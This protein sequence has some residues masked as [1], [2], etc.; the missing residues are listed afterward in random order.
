MKKIQLQILCSCLLLLSPICDASESHNNAMT[1]E[2]VNRTFILNYKDMV[3]AHCVAKAYHGDR[4]AA[5][6]AGSSVSALQDWLDYYMDKSIDEEVRLINSYLSRDYF[7]PLAE[8]EVN[9]LKFDFLK[10]LDLYH[11]KE[12]DKLARKVVPY[13][14]RKASQGY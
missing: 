11:S 12:L 14:Q 13:P 7:N 3:L 8:S 1:P 4:N 6:D 10:C 2:A 5:I 9:G